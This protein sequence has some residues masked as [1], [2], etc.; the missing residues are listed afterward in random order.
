[1][2]LPARRPTPLSPST[3]IRRDGYVIHFRN[4]SLIKSQDGCST[5]QSVL[6]CISNR[7][8][9]S[10]HMASELARDAC[11]E[12]QQYMGHGG[13]TAVVQTAE[14]MLI[15]VG[16]KGSTSEGHS[17]G[18]VPM[19]RSV[20]RLQAFTDHLLAIWPFGGLANARSKPIVVAAIS[21]RA[22]CNSIGPAHA[23]SL[24]LSIVNAPARGHVK[25]DRQGLVR[26]LRGLCWTV[27]RRAVAIVQPIV[28]V[29]EK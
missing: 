2:W 21:S 18:R 25:D 10:T 7:M 19:Y 24:L 13:W 12:L 28:C 15:G 23:G 16:T 20:T 11:I 29:P 26:T 1:M 5:R 9:G 14:L 3:F 8:Y 27:G 17:R 22:R 6:L 4:L